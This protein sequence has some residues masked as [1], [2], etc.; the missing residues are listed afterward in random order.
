M[1]STKYK[2]ADTRIIAATNRDLLDLVKQGKFREDLYYRL[3]VINIYLPALSERKEDI[4]ILA[5]YFFGKV[6]KIEQ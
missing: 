2:K 6:C 4:P 1:G 5:H 3:S